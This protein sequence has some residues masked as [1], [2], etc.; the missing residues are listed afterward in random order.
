[1]MKQFKKASVAGYGAIFVLAI[2]VGG[3]MKEDY[4]DPNAFVQKYIREAFEK[5]CPRAILKEF[6]YADVVFEN[7]T[8]KMK[9]S[10]SGP[11]NEITCEVRVVPERRIKHYEL[12]DVSWSF[13]YGLGSLNSLSG[14]YLGEERVKRMNESI[15]K[16]D[17]KKPL[18][19]RRVDFSRRAKDKEDRATVSCFRTRDENGVFVPMEVG[20]KIFNFKGVAWYF[21]RGR[22]F[23][24]KML[25]AKRGFELETSEGRNA[26]VA[27]SNRCVT[28]KTAVKVIN[29][30]VEEM[31]GVTNNVRWGR[32]SFVHTR[33]SEMLKAEIEPLKSELRKVEGDY[34]RRVATHQRKLRDLK[35]T[36]ENLKN[37]NK[38]LIDM[39]ARRVQARADMVVRL[40]KW[41]TTTEHPRIVRQRSIQWEINNLNSQI[42]ELDKKQKVGDAR[43]VEIASL[44]ENNHA[45]Q[46][47]ITEESAS[48]KAETEAKIGELK[49]RIET[50]TNEVKEQAVAEG[51]K[52]LD[53]LQQR[54]QARVGE[55]A[56]LLSR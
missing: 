12:A 16:F 30:T 2:V 32:S 38:R 25:K 39:Q 41:K 55:L 7:A 54:L 10:M 46:D 15:N 47:K 40:E 37:E 27:F 17:A 31:R 56:K 48:D 51:T 5:N 20:G 18:L 28:V 22:V 53:E 52:K 24:E 33:Y 1:M 14:A 8:S 11:V 3:C 35:R 6:Q 36:D 49:K 21:R 43:L 29:A 13:S 45:E 42:A 26:Y 44:M 4:K 50:R 9:E 19:V 34:G 23:G